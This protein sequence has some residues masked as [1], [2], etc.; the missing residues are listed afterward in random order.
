MAKKT[1][2]DLPALVEAF[3]Q[4][5]N[6][7]PREPERVDEVPEFLRESAPGDPASEPIDGW[8]NWRVVR[9]DNSTQIDQL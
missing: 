4:K 5:I 8:T 2:F 3:V 6:S 7:D 1:T 9:R